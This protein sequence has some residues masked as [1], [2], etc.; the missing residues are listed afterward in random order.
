MA[1]FREWRDDDRRYNHENLDLGRLVTRCA[2]DQIKLQWMSLGSDLF[3]QRFYGR[4]QCRS[5]FCR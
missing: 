5:N 2:M 3:E 1:F 4:M